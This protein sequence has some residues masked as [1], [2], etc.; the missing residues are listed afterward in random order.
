VH[1][2]TFEVRRYD[3]AAVASAIAELQREY[4]RRY[5]S[6]DVAAVD[7]Q[8]FA[9]AEGLF[10][11]SI[12][13]EAICA[14]GGWRRHDEQSVEIKRMYVPQRHR[15]RGFARAILGELERRALEVGYRRA[16]L[17]TGLEQPEAV[18]MY[19]ACGYRPIP[20]FGHYANAPLAVF[21]GKNL[22]P[23]T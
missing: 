12:V 18:A 2:L 14:M 21:F 15:R 11:V 4:V 19:E 7:P 6:E 23:G 9:A 1:E 10:L 13:Y 3:D 17:N 8:V 16:V 5:G 22:T 20:G